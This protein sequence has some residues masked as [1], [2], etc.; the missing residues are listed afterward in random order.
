MNIKYIRVKFNDKIIEVVTIPQLAEIC[1]RD[2]ATMRKYDERS[3]MPDANVRGKSYYN[4][5]GDKIPGKRLYSKTLAFRLCE[6][7][8]EV[9]Q[10]VAVTG[11]QKRLIAVAFQEEKLLINENI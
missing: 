10:G 5:S 7:L 4:K 11:E 2:V 9:R 1:N 6:I 3:I 8:K